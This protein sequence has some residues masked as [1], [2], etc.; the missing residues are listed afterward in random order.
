LLWQRDRA[1]ELLGFRYRIEIYTPAAKRTHGYYCMPI[2]HNGA[3]VGVVDPKL[4]R[5]RASLEGRRH[6]LRKGINHIQASL[7]IP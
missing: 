7:F 4:H 3:V 1:E 2:L 6:P 5:D